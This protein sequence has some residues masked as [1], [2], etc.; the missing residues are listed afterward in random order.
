M[1]ATVRATKT[2]ATKKARATRACTFT[3]G[4]FISYPTANIDQ[5]QPHLMIH[6]NAFISKKDAGPAMIAKILD[7]LWVDIITDE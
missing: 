6:E 1:L 2:A 7:D 5:I 3:I 4:T